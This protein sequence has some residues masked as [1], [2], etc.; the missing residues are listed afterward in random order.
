LTFDLKGSI[1]NR[2]VPIAYKFKNKNNQNFFGKNKRLSSDS[3]FNKERFNKLKN[4]LSNKNDLIEEFIDISEDN[5][6][7]M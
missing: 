7:K 3:I 4:S 2:K 5:S 6:I 1:E